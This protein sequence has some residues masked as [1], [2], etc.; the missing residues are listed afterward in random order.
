MDELALAPLAELPPAESRAYLID[1]ARQE[2]DAALET[3]RL[4]LAMPALAAAAVEALGEVCAQESWRLL[5]QVAQQ[6]ASPALRKAARRAQHRL[7]SRGFIP[8]PEVRERAAMPVEQARA[9]FFDRSGGQFLR[10]VRPAHL[11]MVRYAGFV[12]SPDGLAEC[13]YLLK[14]RA[15]LDTLLAEEDRHFGQDLVEMGLGYVARRVR[16]AAARSR[17]QG[18]PLPE[19]YFETA[20]LLEDAPEDTSLDGIVAEP[21]AVSVEEARRLLHHRSMRS[22]GL[23]DKD[24][25]PYVPDWSRLIESQPRWT[26]EGLLNLGALQAY[27]QMAA[28]IIGDLIDE[29]TCRRL[30]QQLREQAAILSKMGEPTLAAIALRCAAGLEKH[31]AAGDPFL[32]ALVDVSMEVALQADRRG[33]QEGPWVALRGAGGSLWVPRPKEE[34]EGPAEARPSGLWLPEHY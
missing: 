20:Q 34:T 26:R 32:E 14:S 9:S 29:S 13:L 8:V 15:D 19:D 16:Q 12:L 24:L 3:L 31:P 5:E 23:S 1:L 10:L 7:R 4:A 2:R 21:T 27:G 33:E 6:G 17:E 30:V 25:Q 22:W 28:R 18:R 11:G